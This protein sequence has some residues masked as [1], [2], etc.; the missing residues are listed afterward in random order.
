[1]FAARVPTLPPATHTNCYALGGRD[2]L[3]VEAI[4]SDTGGER[5]YLEWARAFASQGRKLVAIVTTHHHPDHIIGLDVLAR[6]LGLG[7]WLHDAT[8]ARLSTSAQ[9]VVTRRLCDGDEIVLDG[10]RPETWN[11]LITPGHAS[12]HV[13][14]HEP[15]ARTLVVGDMVASVGTILIAPSDGDVQ[16]YILSLERLAGLDAVLAL[17]SHGEPI[18][19]PTALFLKY[20]AH[21]EK[22]EK[23]IYEAVAA[24]GPHGG[25]I[26]ELLATSYRGTPM[27]LWPLAQLTLEAHLVKLVREGRVLSFDPEREPDA[28]PGGA[29][30]V[31]THSVSAR[32]RVV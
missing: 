9:A 14:L 10:I 25:T 31:S 22:R 21:R 23:I 5:A 13:C 6:E 3:L 1:M 19:K 28:L 15:K 12:G 29:S 16:K 32:F 20:I 27:H 26:A 17:P 11:V 4:A 24:C 8:F 2:V 18:D 30:P 7:V